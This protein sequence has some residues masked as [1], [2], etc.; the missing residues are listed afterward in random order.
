[1]KRST[2]YMTHT[3]SY[4]DNQPGSC[5]RS[6]VDEW[7]SNGVG[8]LGILGILGTLGI[9]GLGTLGGGGSGGGTRGTGGDILRGGGMFVTASATMIFVRG[10]PHF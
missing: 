10:V 8:T 2:E 5:S 1:M 3:L 7:S 9:L 6:C 4:E